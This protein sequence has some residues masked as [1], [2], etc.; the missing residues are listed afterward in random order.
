MDENKAKAIEL[1]ERAGEE[2]AMY[3]FAQGGIDALAATLRPRDYEG[4]AKAFYDLWK[5]GDEAWQQHAIESGLAA[6]KH[7]HPY[8][9]KAFDEVFARGARRCAEMLVCGYLDARAGVPIELP[10]GDTVPEMKRRIALLER[11]T[12]LGERPALLAAYETGHKLFTSKGAR[13][14]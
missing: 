9:Y 7:A 2:H 10:Q 11:R 13:R 6:A 14:G 8:Y 5:G 3:V 12:R 1:G 4:Y